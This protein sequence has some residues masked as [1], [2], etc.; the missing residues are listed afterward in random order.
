VLTLALAAL[1]ALPPQGVLEPGRSLAGIRL[2][3]P[4]AQVRRAWGPRFGVCRGCPRRTLYF[5]YSAFNAVG[6]AAEFVR[7]RAV[8]LYTLWSPPGWRT[9]DA[10]Q[11]GAEELHVTNT[12]RGMLRAQC[13]HYYAFT[14]R[15]GRVSTVFWFR[16]GRL[17]S[18]G[19]QRPSLSPC[20]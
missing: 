7:G 3:T 10:V 15:R 14:L 6:V 8:A 5:T 11:L 2:G 19:L 1:L 9:I 20:R 17:W 12:Y 13:G 4:E 16:E 18:F